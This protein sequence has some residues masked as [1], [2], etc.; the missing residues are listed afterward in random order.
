MI[1]NLGVAP[2]RKSPGTDALT[3]T[4]HPDHIRLISVLVEDRR[5]VLQRITNVL[6]RRGF[7]IE[8]CAVGPS[9]EPGV[10]AVS[11]RVDAGTQSP[12]QITKQIN[13]LIDVVSVNDITDFEPVEWSTA[14][15][16]LTTDEVTSVT[17]SLNPSLSAIVI[18]SGAQRTVV[19]LSGA[20]DL[21]EAALAKM[22]LRHEV[23][24][25]CSGPLGLAT[26]IPM[27]LGGYE[28]W[29]TAGN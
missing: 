1:T 25:I 27:A 20:P 6:G 29:E 26:K 22:R 19:A 11:L 16:D 5:G 10:V 13:K 2:P 24:W 15:L 3:T 17:D 14:L 7:G 28:E 21:V 9:V 4:R 12:D 8:T 23:N 18:K